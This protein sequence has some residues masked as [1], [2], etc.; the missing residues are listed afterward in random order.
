[1]IELRDLSLVVGKG[2][3]ATT[4]LEDVSALLP[5]NK[6]LVILGQ[7][8]SGKTSLIQLLSGM[9]NPE[10][11]EIRR[12]ARLS[13][14][15]GF[16]RGFN[17]ETTVIQ[18]IRHHAE[19]YGADPREICDFVIPLAGLE[20]VA[21]VKY[22]ALPRYL[23]TKLAYTLSYAIPF[24]TYLIDSA[25]TT[26]DDDFRAK[27]QTMFEM[28]SE[29]SGI[30]LA[31]KHIRY[32]RKIAEMVAVIM[33]RSIVLYED[34]EEAIALYKTLPES[35]YTQSSQEADADEIDASED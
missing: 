22:S 4:V 16:T 8:G 28:R 23:R 6:R 29:S 3:R 10:S 18:N 33:N 12:Y 14:P 15:V 9:L 7:S 30:I 17:R 35:H 26:G 11:G 20:G 27:C 19:I 1:M 34:V 31:T 25:W 2:H 21:D 5:T 24:D 32:T 13:Y